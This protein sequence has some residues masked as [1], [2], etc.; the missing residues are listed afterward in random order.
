MIACRGAL[1]AALFLVACG[2]SPESAPRAD[3]RAELPGFSL[4]DGSLAA[5][6]GALYLQNKQSVQVFSPGAEGLRQFLGESYRA[7]PWTNAW[8]FGPAE[9]ADVKITYGAGSAYLYQPLCGL[10]SV[11][12]Q[13]PSKVTPIVRITGSVDVDAAWGD[14][15]PARVSPTF[16]IAAVPD[17]DGLLVCLMSGN[18]GGDGVQL[19]SVSRDGKPGEMVGRVDGGTDCT[20]VLRDDSGAFLSVYVGG[21]YR[22]DRGSRAV[23]RIATP[24]RGGAESL[25][26]TAAHLFYLEGD[27][28]MRVG[29]DGKGLTRIA[30]DPEDYSFLRRFIA[31]ERNLYIATQAKVVRIPQDGGP[32][33][34]M[35]VAASESRVATEDGF[36]KAGDDLWFVL[37]QWQGKGEQRA[38]LARVPK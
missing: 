14:G 7:C 23:T 29:R 2:S 11:S 9:R 4:S 13:D 34:T 15:T 10:W 3:V 16:N 5:V 12:L 19:W 17:G 21:V 30:R 31:D 27:E 18:D 25:Q 6:D 35:L 20:E 26:T 8:K 36:V 1:V 37:N 24:A 38:S 28:I 22:W 32:A 33:Q